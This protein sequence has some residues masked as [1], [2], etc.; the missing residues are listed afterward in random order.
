MSKYGVF[1]G[2]YFSVFGPEK[3]PY[4][5]TFHAVLSLHLK[6][7][8]FDSRALSIHLYGVESW[9]LVTIIK[10]HLNSFA[11]SCYRVMLNI[12]RTDTIRNDRMLGKCNRRNFADLLT[13]SQLR[14]LG[15]G[16]ERGKKSHH[17]KN[18]RSTL[19]TDE[20][21]ARGRPRP[22]YVKLTQQA[23]YQ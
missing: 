17:L 19:P 14:T 12:K 3:I 11:T 15:H 6:L 4:L 21:I 18:T 20:K 22:T 9:T 1:S 13:E 2:P 16:K 7:R 10:N 5:D 23:I 8:F